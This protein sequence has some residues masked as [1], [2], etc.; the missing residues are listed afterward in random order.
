M[1]AGR[2]G[3]VARGP[4]QELQPPA[5][6][7]ESRAVRA[8]AYRWFIRG[9]ALAFGA[10]LAYGVV[11]A[12]TLAVRELLLV[13][14]AILLGSAL[15]PVVGAVRARTGSPRGP[16]ILLVYA[17]FLALVLLL[18]LLVVPEAIGQA[19]P[20][21]KGI[22]AFVDRARSWAT[23]LSPPVNSIVGTLLYSVS[24][25]LRSSS[26]PTPD[27]VINAGMTAAE[28]AISIGSVL[29]IV[30]FWMTERA[31]LQRYALSFIP[32][33]RRTG[34]HEAWN[35]VELRL[36]LWVR[37]Q[38][39]LMAIMALATGFAYTVIGL[40]SSLLV[41]LLA[42]IA[43]AIPIVGPAIGAVPALVVAVALR[44]DLLL[45][46]AIAYIVIHL[47]ESNVLVPF[48]M[49]NTIGISPF[50][51]LVSLMIGSAVGGVAGGFIAVPVA[52]AVEAVLERLQDR[53]LPVAQ[54][55]A[56]APDERERVE[57]TPPP[58]SAGS[59]D[60]Q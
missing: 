30:F 2:K 23:T 16:I 48:V 3:T 11:V 18:A 49:R 13:F 39:T 37:G 58:D 34:V 45:P 41:A 9:A 1:S 56:H 25:G 40:P 4:A 28:V 17:A 38:L 59:A 14:I 29:A 19:Q 43:E 35:D 51:V 54:E 12:A 7:R 33:D 27:V 20:L 55:P 15:E 47:V 10:A 36:G 24:S 60:L 42:G 31:R 50:M 46:V 6:T 53:E 26:A 57:G 22:P 32:A 21:A 5:A 8:D 44:P 52:A